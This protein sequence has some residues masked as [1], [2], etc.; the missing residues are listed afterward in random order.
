MGVTHAATRDGVRAHKATIDAHLAT[1]GIPI[2]HTAT[3]WSERAEIR[4]SEI[5][6]VIY[7]QWREKFGQ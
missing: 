4:P 5:S 3:F 1:C 2:L 7:R 6:P